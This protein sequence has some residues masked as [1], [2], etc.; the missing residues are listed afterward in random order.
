M[1]SIILR[2]VGVAAAGKTLFQDLSFTLKKGT[3]PFFAK[4]EAKKG[5]VPFL[6]EIDAPSVPSCGRSRQRALGAVGSAVCEPSASHR[7]L[8]CFVS[9]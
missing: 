3:V 5:T 9:S 4:E 7:F 8:R 2:E 1:G 6:S